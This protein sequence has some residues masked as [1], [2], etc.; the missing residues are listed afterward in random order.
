MTQSEFEAHVVKQSVDAALHLYAPHVV[1]VAVVGVQVPV[2]SH[3]RVFV[4]VEPVQLC[5]WH[6]VPFA[7]FWQLPF[8]S[9]EPFWPQLAVESAEHSPSGSAPAPK[10]EQ[11]PTFPV[12]LHERHVPEHDE[13]QQTPS[14][15]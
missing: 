9:H 4:R 5:A 13:S 2:P 15:Q 10:S 3:E 14:T 11:V 7:Y 8:P 12:W 6:V 1:V